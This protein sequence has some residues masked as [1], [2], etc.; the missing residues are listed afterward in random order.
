LRGTNGKIVL[1][2]PE[3][4]KIVFWVAVVIVLLIALYLVSVL[5]F[6]LG[7]ETPGDGEGDIIPF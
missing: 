4:K 7:G 3:T 1:S 5:L 6:S 2:P